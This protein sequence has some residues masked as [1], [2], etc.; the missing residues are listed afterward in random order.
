MKKYIYIFF[1]S[2]KFGGGGKGRAIEE[3][4]TFLIFFS[5]AIKL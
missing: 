1:N 2:I 5:T 3:I 4:K